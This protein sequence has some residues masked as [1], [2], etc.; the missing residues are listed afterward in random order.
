M[1][2]T[3]VVQSLFEEIGF[4]DELFGLKDLEDGHL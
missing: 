4:G 1:Y 3:A 2:L